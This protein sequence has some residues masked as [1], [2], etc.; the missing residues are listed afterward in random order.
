M[1]CSLEDL[2]LCIDLDGDSLRESTPYDI[3][4]DGLILQGAQYDQTTKGIRFSEDLRHVLAHS[5]L[6]WSRKG[7][8]APVA[9]AEHIFPVYLNESRKQFVCQVVLPSDRSVTHIQWAQRSVA[10]IL[11]TPHA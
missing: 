8:K 3:L 5:K 7:Q 11:Q 6:K 2:E 10:V 9:V 1:K 4:L